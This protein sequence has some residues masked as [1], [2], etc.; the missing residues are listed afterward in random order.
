MNKDFVVNKKTLLWY[1]CF[2]LITV[3]VAIFSLSLV[4]LPNFMQR[5]FDF[6]F[7]SSSRVK[8]ACST[9][10]TLYIKFVYGVL[11]AVMVGWCV[12]LFCSIL[13]SFRREDKEGWRT[14]SLSLVTWFILDTSFSISQG[15]IENAVFNLIV[16][17]CFSIPLIGLSRQSSK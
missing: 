16:F 5:F 9:E 11:G 14:V 10:E 13:D 6:I 2:F 12:S 8:P 15:F 7:F 1:Y 4:L 3:T 17:V